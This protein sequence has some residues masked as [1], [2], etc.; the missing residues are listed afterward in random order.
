MS[1]NGL[2]EAAAAATTKEWRR[3][4]KR[5]LWEEKEKDLYSLAGTAQKIDNP[6][7]P[8]RQMFVPPIPP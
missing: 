8:S 1:T 7:R 6:I 5:L 3:K 2:T 4:E